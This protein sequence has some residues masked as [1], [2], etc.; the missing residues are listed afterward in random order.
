MLDAIKNCHRE[1]AD[2]FRAGYEPLADGNARLS[3]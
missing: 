2:L 1:M 3:Q